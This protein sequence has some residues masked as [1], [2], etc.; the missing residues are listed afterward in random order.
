MRWIEL[1]IV[2]P[3]PPEEAFPWVVEPG[4][5]REW[6]PQLD[7]L[8]PRGFLH[9]R[10]VVRHAGLRLALDVGVTRVVV[11]ELVELD[12]GWRGAVGRSVLEVEPHEDG[13]TVT[14]RVGLTLPATLRLAGPGVAR[15]LRRIMRRDLELLAERLGEPHPSVDGDADLGRA[16]EDPGAQ[17][18]T[19]AQV[20][21]DDDAGPAAAAGSLADPGRV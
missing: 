18:P 20:G 9:H 3:A 8:R 17:P 10:P 1:E 19:G 2:V 15:E 13:S 6:L 16:D 4:L 11:P 7:E 14:W 5:L 12:V 21:A